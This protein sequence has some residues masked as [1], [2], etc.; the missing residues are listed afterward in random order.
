MIPNPATVTIPPPCAKSD[1]APPVCLA[2][3]AVAELESEDELVL[4]PEVTVVAVDFAAFDVEDESVEL[5]SV[6]PVAEAVEFFSALEVVAAVA[7]A[8]FAAFVE[9][10]DEV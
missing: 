4:V 7:A 5:E 9:E 2:V 8:D 3:A 1:T 6:F 10:E